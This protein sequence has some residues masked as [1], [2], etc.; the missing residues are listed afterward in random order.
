MNYNFKITHFTFLSEKPG[1]DFDFKLYEE[2]VVIYLQKGSLQ[3]G[4][5]NEERNKYTATFGDIILCKKGETLYKNAK[6]PIDLC[7]IK[8]TADSEIKHDGKPIKVKDYN[9]LKF[10]IDIL[11]SNHSDIMLIPDQLTQ[12]YCTDIVYLTFFTI[13]AKTRIFNTEYVYIN[14]HFNENIHIEKL[15]EHANFSV[16]HFI[17][18][19]KA[20]YGETPKQYITTLRL[21]N[22]IYL[23]EKTDYSISDISEMCG[24][25][26][27][28]Y[29]SRVFKKY[30]GIS[31][32]T[33]R[34]NNKK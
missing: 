26:D 33:A 7:I 11:K 34:K 13:E 19:F 28:L 20:E 8:F 21:K 10:D 31:P 25:S 23:L 9:R 15:A 12:H 22:A 6:E 24:Y 14:R 17:N 27:P 2:N 29:F 4:F 3:Y 5:S 1:R 32:N 18:L 16:A 30:M